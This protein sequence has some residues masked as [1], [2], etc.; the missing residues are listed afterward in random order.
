MILRYKNHG[1]FRLVSNVDYQNSKFSPI[2]STALERT[3]IIIFLDQYNN[4]NISHDPCDLML[5]YCYMAHCKNYYEFF[6]IDSGA[7]ISRRRSEI[8]W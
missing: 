7:I 3:P 4:Y 2:R 1:K 5:Y 6:I 8:K